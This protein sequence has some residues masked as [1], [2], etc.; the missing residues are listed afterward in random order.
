MG[1]RVAAIKH[2]GAP[3]QRLFLTLCSFRPAEGGRKAYVSPRKHRIE[4][5]GP[6]KEL[7]GEDVILVAGLAEMPHS[8]LKGAPGIKTCRRLAHCRL[9]LGVSDGRRDSDGRGL[10]NFVLHGEN[11]REITVVAL[12]PDMVAGLGLNKLSG[13]ANMAAG[14]ADTTFE[15]V[16]DAELTADPFHIDRAALEG[17]GRI[18]GDHEKR[19]VAGQRRDDVLGD[20]ISEELLL[21]V[22]AHVLEW[23]HHNRRLV[24]QGECGCDL[25]RGGFGRGLIRSGTGRTNPV[26]PNGSGNI[27]ESSFAHIIKREVEPPSGVFLN[28]GRNANASRFRKTFK[29]SGDVHAVAEDVAVLDHDIADVNPDAEFDAVVRCAGITLG[30]ATLP[31]SCT[32]QT[33][34]D[35]AELYQQPITGRFYD[36]PAMFSDLRID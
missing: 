31:F 34:D 14:F 23:Q 15:H 33:V 16:A 18:P 17:K 6:L 2:D 12:G 29:A 26:D 11:V 35:A 4:I 24:G 25:G 36:P 28:T 9:L 7:P 27:L 13:H 1:F 22:A 19:G 5:D 20:P 8:A 30:H 10:S 32:T 3:R 21:R